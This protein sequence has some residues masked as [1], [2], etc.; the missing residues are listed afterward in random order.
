[1]VLKFKK[2]TEVVKRY[3]KRKKIEISKSEKVKLEKYY[4]K[5]DSFSNIISHWK[6][7]V[8]RILNCYQEDRRSP[9]DS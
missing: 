7:R 4:N 6:S 2:I 3:E 9:Y 1:M 8:E 5:L